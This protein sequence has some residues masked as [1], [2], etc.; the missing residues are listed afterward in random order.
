MITSND[1]SRGIVI[2]L[3]GDIFSVLDY[4]HVK[5]A[6]GASGSGKPVAER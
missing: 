5:P 6:R 3:D 1:F 4:Q 2:T